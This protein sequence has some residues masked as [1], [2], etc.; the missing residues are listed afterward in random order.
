ME[1]SQVKSSLSSSDPLKNSIHAAKQ[2]L[3]GDR[4]GNIEDVFL[5]QLTKDPKPK[6][7]ARKKNTVT[8]PSNPHMEKQ[9]R[10]LSVRA[11]LQK[12]GVWFWVASMSGKKKS[13]PRQQW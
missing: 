7:G 12:P 2:F 6:T 11:I 3:D 8:V 13:N 4:V 10:P 1:Q 5:D 9:K